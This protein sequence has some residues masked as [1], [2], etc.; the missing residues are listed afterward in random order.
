MMSKL[1]SVGEAKVGLDG[2]GKAGR[3]K[4]E[5]IKSKRFSTYTVW[6]N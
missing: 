3:W 6:F 1:V 5:K 4:I 2:H